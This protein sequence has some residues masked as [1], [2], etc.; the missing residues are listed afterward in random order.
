MGKRCV[1]SHRMLHM[2]QAWSMYMQQ[3]MHNPSGEKSIC[4]TILDLSHQNST[5]TLIWN[6]VFMSDTCVTLVWHLCDTS[7]TLVWHLCDTCVT[8]VWHLCAACVTLCQNDTQKWT[9]STPKWYPKQNGCVAGSSGGCWHGWVIARGQMPDPP[10][11][12]RLQWIGVRR[13]L[14]MRRKMK[15]F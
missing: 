6:P 8:L 13:K 4:N 2:Q 7:V 12:S 11:H 9:K 10:H 3:A 5:T 15:A 14:H 1:G